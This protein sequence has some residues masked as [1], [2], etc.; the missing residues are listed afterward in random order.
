MKEI[1]QANHM[2]ERTNERKRKNINGTPP[3]GNDVSCFY[4]YEDEP[5]IIQKR[6]LK[7]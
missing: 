3:I 1:G 5:E 4:I 6:R 2:N 7:R